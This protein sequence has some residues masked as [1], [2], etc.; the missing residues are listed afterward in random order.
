MLRPA[1]V[2]L[3]LIAAPAG[4]E[5]VQS[6]P[7]GFEVS[8]SVTVAAPLERAWA[9]TLAPRLW[10]NKDHTYSGDSANLSLDERPGGCFCEKLPAKG[11]VEHMRVAYIQPPRMIRLIGGLGPVQA[12]GATGAM[13]ITLTKQGEGTRIVMSYVVGGYM[14]QGAEKLAPLV[15]RVLGEQFEGLKAAVEGAGAPAAGVKPVPVGASATKPAA[16]APR[17]DAEPLADVG[18]TI[19]GLPAEAPP[20]PGPA[21]QVPA[22]PPVRRPAPADPNAES[23]R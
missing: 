12:E 20:G 14:R 19:S 17:I 6:S 7:M 16:A 11:G 9:I 18:A 4:A 10:W 8:H 21:A 23:P 13:A 5:V 22:E 15:D 1:V 2:G 3:V